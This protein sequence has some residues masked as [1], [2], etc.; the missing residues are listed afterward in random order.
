VIASARRAVVPA[1]RQVVPT[2]APVRM[3]TITLAR[4]GRVIKVQVP[5]EYA[6]KFQTP[7]G[8]LEDAHFNARIVA[9]FVTFGA[10]TLI[11]LTHTL[12]T[13][14]AVN[15]V[16]KGDLYQRPYWPSVP[17]A[18]ISPLNDVSYVRS[19]KGGSSTASAHGWTWITKLSGISGSLRRL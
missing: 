2:P 8:L 6:V 11:P 10:W 1:V 14:P 19:P 18:R 3:V 17:F 12:P 15:R 9:E 16:L 4:R 13:Y 7:A 5:A